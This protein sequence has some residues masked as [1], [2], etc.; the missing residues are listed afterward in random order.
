MGLSENGEVFK[1]IE[2]KTFKEFIGFVVT[3]SKGGHT[4]NEH[5]MPFYMYCNYC[6]IKYDI[7]G[8][9]EDF[10]QDFRLIM[11]KASLGHLLP[12]DKSRYHIHPSGTQTISAPSHEEIPTYTE[13]VKKYFSQL[14]TWQLDQLYK[15]YK[16][17]FEMFG[18]DESE[19]A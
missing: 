5:W 11:H 9:V 17:D 19:Y 1:Y 10:E 7:I 4:M 12:N 8:R 13:K 16:L 6:G 18:Y 2:N 14:S 3:N 15:L